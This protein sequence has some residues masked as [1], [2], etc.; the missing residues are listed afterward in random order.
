MAPFFLILDFGFG[1]LDRGIGI[2][3]LAPWSKASG[4]ILSLH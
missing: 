2:R 1:I 4:V 3:S